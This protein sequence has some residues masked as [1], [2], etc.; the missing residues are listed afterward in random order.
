V[1]Y[2][3]NKMIAV[4]T[5]LGGRETNCGDL[6][7]N[8][9][10]DIMADLGFGK[11][12]HM[13]DGTGDSTYMAFL[14]QYMST[15]FAFG[16]VR[17]LAE[18][19]PYLPEDAGRKEFIAKG[20]NMSETRRAQG[21]SR[22]DVFTHLLGEDSETGTVFSNI[23][24]MSNAQ[25]M[26]IAGTDTTSVALSCAFRQLAM[27]PEIQQKLHAELDEAFP[28][29]DSEITIAQ[30]HGLKY[31]QGVI[32]ETLRMFPPVPSGVQ[33]MTP[34]D[35]VT[36]DGVFVPGRVAVRVHH[37]TLQ[38]DERYFPRGDEFIPE[39]WEE[40]SQ[41]VRDKRAFIPFSIGPNS[42]LG[43]QL[44]L[45]EMRLVMSKVMRQFTV[46]LGESH[47][48]EKY[49]EGWRDWYTVKIGDLYIKFTPRNI[50]E[51]M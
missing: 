10:F 39:R 1:E 36:I 42:C 2:H 30:I 50:K 44:A 25:L 22:A 31:V 33:T 38:R 51:E 29:V 4:L 28:N 43:K 46:S 26:I 48:D 7:D 5:Q 37:L 21:K 19:I 32:N 45:N 41:L 13:Q 8:M 20:F 15:Y 12:T 6:M 18:M 17:N 24:L 23:Q 14:H 9:A 16:S 34:A 47:D 3:V 27:H 35:G 11:D 49:V 40:G